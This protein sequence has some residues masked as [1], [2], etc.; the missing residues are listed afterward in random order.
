MYFSA[1]VGAHVEYESRLERDEAMALDFDPDAVGYAAQ[2]FWLFW[3]DGVKQ[4]SHAPDFFACLADES[5]VVN[6]RHPFHAD[7]IG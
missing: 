1:T 6:R 7:Q 4:R 5:G 2:P 3:M